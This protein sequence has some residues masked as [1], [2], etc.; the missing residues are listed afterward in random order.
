MTPL[1][2]QGRVAE[3]EVINKSRT[4]HTPCNHRFHE[5]CL[6]QW[7]GIKMECPTCRQVLPPLEE[8]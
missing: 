8:M 1:N 2:L 3:S 4:M 7:M 6:T 5:D